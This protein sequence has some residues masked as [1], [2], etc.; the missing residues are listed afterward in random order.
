VA[1]VGRRDEVIDVAA[2]LLRSGGP[3][4]LTSVN[5][6]AVLGITQSAVYRHVR[7]MDELTALAAHRVVTE[8]AVVM[9]DAVDSPGTTWGPGTDMTHFAG[10]IVELI[11]TYPEAFAIVDRWRFDDGELGAGIRMLVAGGSELIAAELERAWRSEF[12]WNEPFDDTTRQVQRCHAQVVVDD[13][14][15]VA[16]S[17]RDADHSTRTEIE[18]ILALR[19]FAGWCAYVV[20]LNRLLGLPTPPLGGT[21]LSAPARR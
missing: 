12:G 8:V 20:H 3:D 6:A 19:V 16:R 17:V 14:V 11:C 18:R 4:A 13:V 9:A 21:H 2:E 1:D 7:S 15:S 5:V 10:R